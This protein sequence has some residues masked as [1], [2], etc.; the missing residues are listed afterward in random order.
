MK[1][2]IGLTA[3]VLSAFLPATQAL[4][5]GATSQDYRSCDGYGEPTDSGDAM[6]TRNTLL[7]FM[8]PVGYGTTAKSAPASGFAGIASCDSALADVP[9]KYWMRKASLLRARAMHRLDGGDSKGALADLDLADAAAAGM[10]DPMYTRSL[11]LGIAF[12]RAYAIRRAGDQAKAETLAMQTHA[13]RPY[14]RQTG[15]SALVAMGPGASQDNQD[16]LIRNLATLVPAEVD[17]LFV[18]AFRSAHYDTAISLYSQL[19]PPKEIGDVSISKAQL[20]ERDL[21]DFRTAQAFWA[22]RSGAYAFALAALGRASD[23]R[24]AID[25]ARARLATATA[26]P[27]PVVVQ[28]VK[29]HVAEAYRDSIAAAHAQS[30]IESGKII[31]GWV[32]KVEARIAAAAAAKDVK[33]LPGPKK[34]APINTITVQSRVPDG[35]TDPGIDALFKDLPEPEIAA[36]IPPYVEA[37]KPW[38][39]MTGSQ[40]DMDA[41]GYR[42][43]AA[44]ESGVVTVG[45]RGDHGTA[46]TVEEMALLRAADLAR[47]AGKKGIIVVGRKDTRFQVNTT[48]YGTI[49]RTD[50]DGYETR[51]DVVFV[52]PA[53][54]PAQY[55]GAAWRVIDADAVYAALAPVYFKAAET[56]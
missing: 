46:S 1:Y 5:A 11:G 12:V 26:P 23:A 15:T 13:L 22:G 51:L 53:A 35:T 17:V 34:G 30:A 36:R 7:F 49:I 9:A 40:A 45:F 41:E 6:T 37:K 55:A 19:S 31:D 48:M 44:D 29:D 10:N 39:A 8:A 47:Q 14:N 32:P 27:P 54:L 43:S 4:A 50:P 28:D 16:A 20:F 18:R 25:A 42:D 2:T 33:K 3:L 56:K 38:L 24:A 21:R 52:D